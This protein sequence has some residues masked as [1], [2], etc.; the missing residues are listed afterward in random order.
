MEMHKTFENPILAIP[1]YNN[2]ETVHI[3]S[4]AFYRINR[5]VSINYLHV[6]TEIS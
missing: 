6:K 1:I 3:F 4:E 5:F 2:N